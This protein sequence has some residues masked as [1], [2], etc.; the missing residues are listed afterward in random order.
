MIRKLAQLS[1]LAVGF[2]AGPGA[3]LAVDCSQPQSVLDSF[4][5]RAGRSSGGD[6]P[7]GY[8]SLQGVKGS[9]TDAG[10]KDQIPVLFAQQFAVSSGKGVGAAPDYFLV[11]PID[12]SSPVLQQAVSTSTPFNNATMTYVDAQRRATSS[13]VLTTVRI[14]LNLQGTSYSRQYSRVAVIG[15]S[16]A[17]ACWEYGNTKACYDYSTNTRF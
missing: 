9:A 13:D 8:L 14:V 17:K 10:F 6:Q 4:N 15:L 11:I 3:S 12:Q 1:C 2:A 5:A 16:C 7:V